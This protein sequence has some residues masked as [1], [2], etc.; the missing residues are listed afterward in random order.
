ML[1]GEVERQI[2]DML[3][4]RIIQPSTS[5]FCSPI[6]MVKK[7][8]GKSWRFAVDYRRLNAIT[9]KQTY[10]LPLIQDILDSVGGRRYYSN[11][12]FQSGFHQIPVYPEH[13]ERTAFATFLG[14]FEFLR[15]PFGLCSAP[16]TFQ[17]VMESMRKELTDAF[18]IYLDDVVLA[19]DTEDQHLSDIDQ[20]L[21]VIIKYAM[22]LRLDKCSFGK[23]E[24]KYLGF[25]ISEKGI[26]PAKER[27]VSAVDQAAED[28][29]G[30]PL[31]YRG[32]ELL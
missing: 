25:L 8:D 11:F 14:L 32:R 16:A 5:P 17:R 24:I 29:N 22:R 1:R 26:R 2:N 23:S 10:Y 28:A 9:V 6:V 18:F 7:A 27:A 13:V 12:D 4:Q 21:Q 3:R 15:M 30:A 20:F 19:S 31:L